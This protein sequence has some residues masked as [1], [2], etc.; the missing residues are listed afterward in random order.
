MSSP[1]T[2]IGAEAE[3]APP[4][5]IPSY[6]PSPSFSISVPS[7][8][9][10]YHCPTSSPVS[11]TPATVSGERCKLRSGVRH[12]ATAADA[13][14]SILTPQNTS[15]DNRFGNSACNITLICTI[16]I[17]QCSCK[18]LCRSAVVVR[19]VDKLNS[20]IGRLG[21]G[22]SQEFDLGVYVLTSHCNFKTYVNVPHVNMYHIE[23]VLGHRRRTTT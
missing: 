15:G 3:E 8:P 23:S 18:I 7:L 20:R 1:L 2:D 21:Q 12:A 13:F 11:L 5:P 4:L 17:A 16:H 10:F 22:R 19:S 6:P 14:L 9:S